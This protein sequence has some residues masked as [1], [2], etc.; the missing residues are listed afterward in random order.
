MDRFDR[1]AVNHRLKQDGRER[2]AAGSRYRKDNK[3]RI[4][5]QVIVESDDGV[6]EMVQDMRSLSRDN[7]RPEELGLTLTEAKD[8]SK[9]FNEQLSSNKS[10]SILNNNLRARFVTNRDRKRARTPSSSALFSASSS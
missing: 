9:A 6:G 10:L 4:R 3:M 5:V 1:R 7:C 8:C 2:P